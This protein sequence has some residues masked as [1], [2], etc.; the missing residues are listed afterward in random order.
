MPVWRTR[1]DWL[2]TAVNSALEQR[3]CRIELIV[4]DDG[5]PTPAA[6]LLDGVTDARLRIIRIEH[7][8]P[9]AARNAGIAE[10]QGDRIRFVDADDVLERDSTSH[11]GSF[12]NRDDVIA[13]GGTLVCDE[14]LRPRYLIAST[15][16]GHVAGECLLGRFETRLPALLFPRAVVHAAG[17]WSP[18]FP[19]S[20]DWDF[21]LRALDHAPVA[22]DQR[23]ALHY[24]RHPRSV[25]RTA[26]IAA[27]EDAWRRLIAAYF[28]RHPEQRATSLE[29][30]AWAAMGLDRGLA[31]WNT[32]Q[33]GASVQRLSRA[34]LS[35]P[36]TVATK[37]ASRT[38]YRAYRTVRPA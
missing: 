6:S 20:G 28:D 5:S 25:S 14:D 3:G 13:Y 30:R 36:L 33:Y 11:L 2:R 22:G 24:R 18:T 10:A 23:V 31:Y 26:N 21:V 12:M 15:L 34:L 4:V 9:S 37:L 32:G 17:P 8:G 19:V 1:K 27:G 35:A 16:Q 38:A 7:A 29:R